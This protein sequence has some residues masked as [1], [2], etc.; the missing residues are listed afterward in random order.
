MQTNRLPRTL[1]LLVVSTGAL[2]LIAPSWAQ[3]RA[4]AATPA[5]LAKYD[6]NKNG[7]L[8]A[9]ELAAMQADE[10]KNASAARPAPKTSRSNSRPSR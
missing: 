6:T 4:A 9:N 3:Q 5:Q 2:S 7:V 1:R 10:A 8:D